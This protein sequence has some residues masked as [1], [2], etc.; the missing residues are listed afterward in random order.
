M[1]PGY[2][3]RGTRV[4]RLMRGNEPLMLV[5]RVTRALIRRKAR[6]S[7]QRN[8]FLQRTEHLEQIPVVRASIKRQV[9]QAIVL[10]EQQ[11]MADEALV[12]IRQRPQRSQLDRRC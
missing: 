5:H 6:W 2:I 11:R 1:G 9:K 4:M 8:R 7:Q 3:L 10:R 12:P